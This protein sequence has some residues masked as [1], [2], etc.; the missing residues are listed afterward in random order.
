MKAKLLTLFFALP[1]TLTS[2]THA[3]NDLGAS[4][5]HY[6]FLKHLDDVNVMNAYADGNF[7]PESI[8]NRAEALT[9][10]LRAGGIVIPQDFG[11]DTYYEDVDPNQWYA[12]VVARAVDTGILRSN[13]QFFRPE[14]AITKS[15]FLAFLFRA[16]VVDLKP[17]LASR[18]IASDIPN[19]S[20]M[21]PYFAYA[22][23][24]QI[25]ELPSD[26]LYRPKKALSRR[27]VGLL[28][29]RQLRL[30][31]GGSQTQMVVEL[32]A[33]IK[34]F[35]SLVA[36]GKTEEAEF[37]VHHIMKLN[38]KIMRTKNNQDAVAALSISRSMEHLS[39]SLRKFRY[40]NNLA[41]IES[42]H[43]A[44]KQAQRAEEKSTAMAPFA[45]EL[46]QLIGE[47]LISFV[48]PDFKQFA[49]N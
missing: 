42:L 29:Y 36:E 8:V 16:T 3:F 4:D 26:N 32:Q 47:T 13:G 46:S 22:K 37:H 1:L 38:D 41:A 18:N 2:T 6:S 23:R 25:A 28:S 15:E 43:L 49:E 24:F 44:L 45:K 10:A 11:G 48:E 30:F 9:I 39:N 17:Y 19:E 31:H 7:Y 27:E 14:E 35:L 5:P 34:Q 21:T 12:P 20:W 40:G 33:S